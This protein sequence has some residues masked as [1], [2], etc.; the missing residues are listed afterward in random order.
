MLPLPETILFDSFRLI[1]GDATPP[2]EDAYLV[3]QDGLIAAAGPR[4]AAPSI[5]GVRRVNLAGKTVMPTIVNI[6]GHIGYLK[7]ATTVKENYSR[8]NV[9]D[10]LHRLA[11]YGVS[12]FQSLGTDRD[13]TEIAIRDEQRAGILIDPELAMLLTAS[14]GITAP[15]PGAD[16]G[17]PFFATDVIHEASA[18]DEAR[19]I[20][21]A[22]ATKNPDS[23]KFW[24]DDRNGTKA[25][26]QEPAFHAIIDE[27]HA[28]GLTAIAHVFALDDAKAVVRAGVDAIAHMVREPGADD[29]LIRL[30]VDNDVS[31]FTSMSIQRA[32]ADGLDWMNDPTLAETVSRDTIEQMKE[33]LHGF[34]ES[35]G[36]A[37][38]S[39][40]Q[41][42]ILEEGLRTY[43][44][45]GVRVLLSG[46]TGVL[47]QFIGYAEHRELESMVH[48][49]M[50]ALQ[51]IQAATSDPAA[52]LGLPDRGSLTP[53]KRADF[54]VLDANP[55]EDITNTR[56]IRDVYLA[57]AAIDRTAMRRRWTPSE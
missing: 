43:L 54:L 34:A 32:M 6:H 49:G 22:I 41:Y 1:T 48:A 38:F 45:G 42:T 4:E 25:K 50:P 21:R 13:D 20:V 40:E 7:G 37:G 57:G 39:R 10:H 23:I 19:R 31:A 17:G 11:Y 44:S 12:V 9:L 27:A 51:A 33:I 36:P 24:V 28:L 15:T 35:H 52:F 5:A 18:P 2:I 46:D 16:N 26:L 47:S 29:E 53:G 14:D 8:E 56:R 30:L 55:L 3:V